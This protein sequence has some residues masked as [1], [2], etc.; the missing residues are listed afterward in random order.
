MNFYF[1]KKLVTGSLRQ[2]DEEKKRFKEY[3]GTRG[4][5]H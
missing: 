5:Q 4:Q 1:L 2:S 3:H